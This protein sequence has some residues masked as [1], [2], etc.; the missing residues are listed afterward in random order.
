MENE[1]G[2]L[3]P[4][5]LVGAATFG[6][7]FTISFVARFVNV[8]TG[9]PLKEG[10]NYDSR[11]KV[12]TS[13]T[14]NPIDGKMTRVWIARADG[15]RTIDVTSLDSYWQGIADD[16]IRTRCLNPQE[17]NSISSLEKVYLVEDSNCLKGE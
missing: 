3:R 15:K 2:C 17:L 8:D 14:K 6:V 5:L 13:F 16:V 11:S 9:V 1:S 12:L 7:V 10:I 4:V